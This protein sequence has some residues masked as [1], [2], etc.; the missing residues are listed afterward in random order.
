M[1]AG[2]AHSTLW[3]RAGRCPL[4]WS[5]ADPRLWVSKVPAG[6]LLLLFPGARAPPGWRIP[7]GWVSFMQGRPSCV[8]RPSPAPPAPHGRAVAP[9]ATASTLRDP[10]ES[11][12]SE[13]RRLPLAFLSLRPPLPLAFARKHFISPE[14]TSE[15]WGAPG[16]VEQ[17][18]KLRS[19]LTQDLLRPW[20]PWLGPVCTCAS[21]WGRAVLS[22]PDLCRPT[23]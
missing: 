8:Q 10:E 13:L 7:A 5:R 12:A 4:V 18:R 6:M 17:M 1:L 2:G 21:S 16:S 15:S 11:R 20:D 14:V 9:A 23:P 3:S 22:A 19:R